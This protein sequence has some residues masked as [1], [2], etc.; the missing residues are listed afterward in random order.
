MFYVVL[1]H[2]KIGQRRPKCNWQGRKCVREHGAGN[3]YLFLPNRSL[4]HTFMWS[5]GVISLG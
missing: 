4:M 1:Q 2:V 5:T 3:E